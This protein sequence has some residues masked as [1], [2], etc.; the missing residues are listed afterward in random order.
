MLTQP[1]LKPYV[2][3]LTPTDNPRFAEFEIG[4]LERCMGHTIGNSLR[5]VLLEMMPGYAVTNLRIPGILHQFS[6][7]PGVVEDAL[8][9]TLNLKQL[10]VRLHGDDVR[11]VTIRATKPGP[12]RAG[13]LDLPPDVEVLNP[14]LVICN[15]GADGKFEAEITIRAGRGFVSAEQ[16]QS[17]SVG[18]IAIDG[19][20]SPVERVSVTVG[21]TRV[22]DD[23]DLDKVTL[24]IWTDGSISPARALALAS[25]IL[26]DHYTGIIELAPDVDGESLLAHPPEQVEPEEEDNVPIEDLELSVRSYNALQNAGVRTLKELMRFTEADLKKVR[27]LGKKSLQEIVGKLAER[28]ITL[29]KS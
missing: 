8:Q 1:M 29:K 25:K 9:I 4:P 3:A 22:Q 18:D 6:P 12:L 13:D 23:A 27:N 2:T 14:D 28:G 5:R 24:A 10:R 20:F 16:F 15:V 7:V 19:N 26:I 17:D 21:K 11:T